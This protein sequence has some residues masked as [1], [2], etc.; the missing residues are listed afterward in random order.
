MTIEAI[1]WHEPVTLRYG[2]TDY[3]RTSLVRLVWSHVRGRRVLDLRCLGGELAVEFASRGFDVT[4]LDGHAEAVARTNERARQAGVP[5]PIAEQWDLTGLA[6]RVNG[7]RFDTV[8]CLDVLNHVQD[9]EV[10]VADIGHVLAD[11]GRVILMVP[12]FPG[13]LGAR[14]RAL[15][16][17]RRYTQKGLRALLA[18]HG[19]AVQTMRYWNFAALPAYVVI[20]RVMRGRVPDGMRYAQGGA[21]GSGS[22]RLLR[23]WYTNVENR[24]R[25]PVGLSLFVVAEKRVTTAGS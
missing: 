19:L 11:G 4:A 12:A 3:R 2:E 22:N 18:R 17:L 9:D 25:F 24:V 23:W 10:T 15:G 7:R 16:H 13:L 14:D 1:Q 21:F 20:E 8:L 6:E 5:E